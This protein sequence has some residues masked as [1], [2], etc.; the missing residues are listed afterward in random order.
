M[1]KTRLEKNHEDIAWVANEG[2]RASRLVQAIKDASI[3]DPTQRKI[4]DELITLW[5][6]PAAHKRGRNAAERGNET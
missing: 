2:I 4:R 6:A 3:G 1:S 5:S